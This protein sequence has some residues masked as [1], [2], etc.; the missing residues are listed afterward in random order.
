MIKGPVKVFF[1]TKRKKKEKKNNN[2][3]NNNINTFVFAEESQPACAQ[4]K[5]R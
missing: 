1:Q 2:N 4:W 5:V 3:N